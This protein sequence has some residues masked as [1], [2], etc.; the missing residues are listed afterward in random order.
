[1]FFQEAAYLLHLLHLYRLLS[2]RFDKVATQWS[3]PG[4]NQQAEIDLVAGPVKQ[5][6]SARIPPTSVPFFYSCR[7]ESIFM[8]KT[9]ASLKS[10]GRLSTSW[11]H[12]R[13]ISPSVWPCLCVSTQRKLC[14]ATVSGSNRSLLGLLQ[15]H[16]WSPDWLVLL[17]TLWPLLESVRSVRGPSDSAR[18]C[19]PCSYRAL[20]PS[21]APEGEIC[22]QQ[23]KS[24]H[25]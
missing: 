9:W 10:T 22:S 18:H 23:R 16:H 12:E 8:N 13:L 4:H 2:S 25:V 19:E 17:R 1:M 7:L 11:T 15:L 5:L 14:L 24:C 6:L 3:S 21:A 20:R